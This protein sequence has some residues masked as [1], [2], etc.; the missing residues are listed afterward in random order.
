MRP[1]SNDLRERVATAVDRR[2]G[3]L[4]QI[5]CR[6]CVSLSFVVRLL[7]RRRDADTLE[8]KPHGGARLLLWDPTTKSASST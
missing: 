4:R 8:P 6:F 2:D 5:A 3:S 1:Y 7:Q